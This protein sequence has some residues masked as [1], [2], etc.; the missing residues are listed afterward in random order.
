M[1]TYRTQPLDSND[2]IAILKCL[3][4]M[5]RVIVSIAKALPAHETQALV[6]ELDSM[7]AS[8]VRLVDHIEKQA[9]AA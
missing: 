6:P 4:E 5:Q 9:T 2:A 1:T 7:S 3:F 8:I